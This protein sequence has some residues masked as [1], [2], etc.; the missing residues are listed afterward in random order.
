LL[1]QILVHLGVRMRGR[2]YGLGIWNAPFVAGSYTAEDRR[3]LLS[4]KQ[5]SDPHHLLNPNKFFGVRT[6]FFNFPGLFFLP[7]VFKT[8]LWLLSALT[9]LLGAAARIGR[10][11][12]GHRWVPPPPEEE[13]GRRLAAEAS[14]RCTSCGSCV[15]ACPAYL[16]TRDELVTGRAKLRMAESWLGGGEIRKEE[17]LRPFQ[18][19]NCGLGEE[20]CQ[21]RLPLR[22]CYRVIERWIERRQGHPVDLVQ[23]FVKRLDADRELIKTVFGLDLP[24]WSPG[25]PALELREIRRS[26]EA[27]P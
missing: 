20:V 9:P 23:D 18:C 22:D 12:P 25:G 6:R 16:L 5:E 17:A 1:V 21:T 14:L 11:S 2:A 19:L 26:M 13:D 10:S 15:S 3:R 8:S 27:R 4:R 7:A 24:D